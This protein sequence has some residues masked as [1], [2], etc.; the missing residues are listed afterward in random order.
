MQFKHACCSVRSRVQKLNVA[1]LKDIEGGA[2]GGTWEIAEIGCA[3]DDREL[4]LGTPLLTRSTEILE[5]H[6]NQTKGKWETRQISCIMCESI[7]FWIRACH[8]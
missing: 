7:D 6:L 1:S 2:F 4:S 8:A 5:E 3:K